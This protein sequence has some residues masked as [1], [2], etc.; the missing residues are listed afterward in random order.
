LT[1]GVG[2]I[3]HAIVIFSQTRDRLSIER[4]CG[5]EV[6]EVARPQAWGRVAEL[7]RWGDEVS[8]RDFF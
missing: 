4:R 6:A 2:G 8:Q 1:H 3:L 5:H 7:L